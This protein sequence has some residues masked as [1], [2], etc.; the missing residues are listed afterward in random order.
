MSHVHPPIV[1]YSLHDYREFR[2]WIGGHTVPYAAY[3]RLFNQLAARPL[4]VGISTDVNRGDLKRLAL[5]LAS[6]ERAY[7][8]TGPPR[9]YLPTHRPNLPSPRRRCSRRA[10][11]P[12]FTSP[13]NN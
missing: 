11:P 3:R 6:S 5:A 13:F 8:Q 1:R 9:T 2:D 7:P 4:A 12:R 10:P